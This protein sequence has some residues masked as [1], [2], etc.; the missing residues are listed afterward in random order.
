MGEAGIPQDSSVGRRQFETVMEQQ[1]AQET[2]PADWKALRRGWFLGDAQFK[3]EV[4]AQTHKCT[5]VLG[6]STA[7]KNARRH[8]KPRR[9]GC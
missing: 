3:K 8:A 1:R 7:V 9:N 2:K 5:K 6:R 4:L